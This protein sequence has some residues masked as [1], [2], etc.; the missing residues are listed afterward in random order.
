M[1]CNAILARSPL[2]NLLSLHVC[3]WLDTHNESNWDKS[4]RYSLVMLEKLVSDID[5]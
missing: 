1:D 3:K 2:L 5:E 4:G